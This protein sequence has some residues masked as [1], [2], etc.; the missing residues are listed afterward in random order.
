M[1]LGALQKQTIWCSTDNKG[2]CTPAFCR[3]LCERPHL[4]I[5][6]L[7]LMMAL[8]VV[9]LL[10]QKKIWPSYMI[11]DIYVFPYKSDGSDDW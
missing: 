4:Y 1:I 10:D 9:L 3:L 8:S 2:P 7:V 6:T 11:S 5:S